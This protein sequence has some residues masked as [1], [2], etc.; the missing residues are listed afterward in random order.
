[1]GTITYEQRN[2]SQFKNELSR[3]NPQF[4]PEDD[5]NSQLLNKIN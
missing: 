3:K 5:W 1:M 4:Y 2:D